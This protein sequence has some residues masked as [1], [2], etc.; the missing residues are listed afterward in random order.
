MKNIYKYPVLYFCANGDLL[1]K[2]NFDMAIKTEQHAGKIRGVCSERGFRIDFNA[3]LRLEVPP[4]NWLVRVSDADT[5]L[6]IL[7]QRISAQTLVSVEKFFVAWKVEIF[8]GTAKVFEHTYDP[9][10]CV[11]CFIFLGSVLGEKIM[12]LPY[13]RA[14]AQRHNCRAAFSVDESF[15]RVV[16]RYY[17]EIELLPLSENLDVDPY[18]TYN[19]G[20]FWQSSAWT[21][22]GAGFVPYDMIGEALLGIDGRYVERRQFT[23]LSHR[24]VEE[25]YV[26]IAV[27]ASAVSKCWLYPGG[28]DSV[29]TYLKELGYRVFCIDR[30]KC[31]RYDGY[32]VCMPEGAEDLTGNIPL[33]SRIDVLGHAEFFIGLS[34]GLSWLAD[35]CGIKTILISGFTMPFVEFPA[36]ARVLNKFVCHGCYSD[37]ASCWKETKCPHH[38]GTGREYECSKKI[39]PQQVITAIDYVR[40][41]SHPEPRFF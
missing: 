24:Y 39:T 38:L 5:G 8:D 16:E 34:S 29:V 36:T 15:H 2:D 14:F 22:W 6:K 35:A 31:A 23:S 13:I 1:N 30:D 18:A 9:Q 41:A 3:G 19:I 17:P 26:C 28:W 11:V 12:L 4:G 32:E 10:G 37:P 33:T 20:T 40:S 7:E 27:Q 21:P 25:P